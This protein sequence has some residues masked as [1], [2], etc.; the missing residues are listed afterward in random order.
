MR[1]AIPERDLLRSFV[2]DFG[3][4]G[5]A[6]IVPVGLDDWSGGGILP[7]ADIRTSREEGNASKHSSMK[8]GSNAMQIKDHTPKEKK[9]HTPLID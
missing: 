8:M 4:R 3:D 6:A 2:D 1:A 5:G 9:P 7:Y